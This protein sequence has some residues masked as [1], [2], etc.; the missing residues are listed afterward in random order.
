MVQVI[1]VGN[2]RSNMTVEEIVNLWYETQYGH[3]LKCRK[4]QIDF[5]NKMQELHD[6]LKNKKSPEQQCIGDNVI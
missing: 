5:S 4:A 6:K 1:I 3:H 2:I